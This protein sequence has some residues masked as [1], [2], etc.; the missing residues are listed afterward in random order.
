MEVS[1]FQAA[2]VGVACWL[3]SY[4]NPQPLGTALSDALSKPLVGGAIVGLILGD[5]S[6]GVMMG[7]AI[8]AMYLAQTLIGGAATA[9]MP[10]VAYPTIALAIVAGADS[11]VAV[12]L[13]ATVGVL[14]AALF[15]GY[16]VLCSIFYN[17]CDRAIEN[18]NIKAMKRAFT[19]YPL[20]TCFLIR[21]GITFIIVM[22]GKNYAADILNSIPDMV[23]HIASVLGGI[24][25]AVGISILVTYTLKDMKL[26]IYFLIGMICI[27]FLNLNLVATAVVGASLAVMYY[28]FTSKEST[29]VVD[30]EDEL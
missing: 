18:G 8:Q 9:D 1:V 11:G 25:P 17:A 12:T 3:G 16:E 24:L 21:F 15:T 10:F 20:I 4:E 26:I 2:L 22:L 29:T 27:T 5:L 19:I 7:A 14:G 6:T 23:L 28:M 13:A 30:E